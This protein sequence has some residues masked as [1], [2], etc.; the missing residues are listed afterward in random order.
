MKRII[1]AAILALAAA[2]GEQPTTPTADEPVA[3]GPTPSAAGGWKRASEARLAPVADMLAQLEA[4][5]TS[6]KYGNLDRLLIIHRDEIIADI[7]RDVDYDALTAGQVTR[8]HPFNYQD[9][10]WHPFYQDTDL[11][12]LQ[13]ITKSIT[14]M[15]VGLAIT[16]GE[17]GDIRT[18]K[19]IDFLEGE[20][21]L[22]H[23]DARLEALTV[24][25]LLAMRT[26]LPTE[27]FD[28]SVDPNESSF[29][30]EASDDWVQFVLNGPMS[31]EPGAEWVY[32]NGATQILG[33]ILQEQV[34]MGVE[35]YVEKN[36][37]APLG[38]DRHYWKTSPV[39]RTDTLGGLYLEAEDLA[40]MCKLMMDGGVWNGERILSED[41][42]EKSTT[43]Y[44]TLPADHSAGPDYKYGYKWWLPTGFSENA[45]EGRGYGGQHLLCSPDDDL[46]VVQYR[47]NPRGLPIFEG[48]AD[49][50]PVL[51]QTLREEIL[52]ALQ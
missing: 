44:S 37:F 43:A 12:T 32:H 41:W 1:C 15:A 22:P 50:F 49:P 10:A 13:S 19:V 35:D 23:R 40:K 34:G 14:S 11:H 30:L 31:A 51:T 47:W 33:L 27:V 24:H 2:C 52:P 8:S 5:I 6:P 36:L 16:R 20:F 29:L 28:E 48:P 7:E 39:G 38:I 46:I 3:G 18:M 26:G 17:F 45:F 25:H 9:P 4:D 21:D 42:I